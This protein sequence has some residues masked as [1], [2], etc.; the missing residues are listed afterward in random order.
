MSLLTDL[1]GW[2]MAGQGGFERIAP[3]TVETHGG[4]GLL[5]YAD[6]VFDDFVL[7]VEWRVLDRFDNSGVFI[8]S[9]PLLDDPQ[10]AID[11]G[12]EI[13]IDERGFNPR[14]NVEDDALHVTGALYE[15]APARERASRSTG[16]WNAF[17]VVARGD[18]IEVVLNGVP[19]S[20]SAGAGRELRGHIALQA[21]HEGA[22]VQFRALEVR[23]VR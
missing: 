15:I 12:Y 9:P 18:T 4:S 14:R 20:R 23:S 3:D 10:P 2:R 21:H 8:R 16:E 19:V 7:T 22:R 5:W 13:Q 6:E 17:E 11:R 1:S